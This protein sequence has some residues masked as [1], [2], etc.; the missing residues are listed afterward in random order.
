MEDNQALTHIKNLTQKEEE[1]YG[2]GNLTD[3]DILHL[4]KVKEDLEQCWDYLRQRRA[5]R[6]AGENPD[7]AEIRSIDTI[8]NYK[9]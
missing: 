8:N 4:H 9:N 2:K 7:K 5:R 3:K 6:D 1:L